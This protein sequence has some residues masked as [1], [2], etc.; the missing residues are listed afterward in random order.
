LALSSG[1]AAFFECELLNNK[2]NHLEFFVFLLLAR[3]TGRKEGRKDV[4]NKLNWKSKISIETLS[5][6][7]KKRNTTKERK[8]G[9]CSMYRISDF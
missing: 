6:P 5:E 1:R 9:V 7:Y 8:V 3:A 2:H 4:P